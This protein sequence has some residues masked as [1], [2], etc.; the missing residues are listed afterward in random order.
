MTGPFQPIFHDA[1]TGAHFDISPHPVEWVNHFHPEADLEQD[2]DSAVFN[3][4]EGSLALAK[5]GTF[6]GYTD[7]ETVHE[8]RVGLTSNV[9]FDENGDMFPG[10]QER[11][12]ACIREA[13][14]MQWLFT[15]GEVVTDSEV[16]P[17]RIV[18][19]IMDAEGFRTFEP[20][21]VGQG[22][23]VSA[24]S[25]NNSGVRFASKWAGPEG[26]WTRHVDLEQ[27]LTAR[28]EWKRIF[29]GCEFDS[30]GVP[31]A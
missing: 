31:R 1:G 5:D 8:V 29:K 21:L 23:E 7:G 10:E 18:R 26:R 20:R 15:T 12:A 19:T 6:V 24:T 27:W 16:A 2:D 30:E 17:Q 28:A 3:W 14:A 9:S 25:V 22:W 4:D 13:T 11:P